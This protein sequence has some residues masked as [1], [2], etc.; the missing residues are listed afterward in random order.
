[1]HARSK[2][3]FSALLV[4]TIVVIGALPAAAAYPSGFSEVLVPRG[5]GSPTAMAFAPDGRIFVCRQNGELRIIEN[6]SL[7]TD[8][9]LTVSVDSAGER[10]LLGAAFHPDFANNNFVYVYYTVPGSPPH[11]RVS[12][13]TGNGNEA[14]AASEHVIVDLDNLSGATNHNGGAIHFGNDGKLYIA[15]GDSANSSNS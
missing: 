5:I 2:E 13:F 12:R 6:G 9:F 8:P 7:L 15:V 3:V 10:G 11:N 14:V 4:L 1:M